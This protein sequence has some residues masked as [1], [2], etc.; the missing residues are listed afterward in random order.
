MT[1]R[2]AATVRRSSGFWERLR[3]QIP[4]G[5]EEVVA[6]TVLRLLLI[7]FIL[8]AGYLLI[9]E[10]KGYVTGLERFQVSPATLTFTATPSWVTP[11]IG[12]QL[13]RLPDLPERFS[14]L[15][16]GL[17]KRVAD[18]YERN[19]WVAEVKLVERHFP[20]RLQVA[21]VLRRPVAAVRYRGAYYL[22]DGEAVRLPLRFGSW[23]QPD[24]QLPIVTGAR[25]QPPRSGAVW[26]DEAVRAG[27]GVAK[28]LQTYGYGCQLGVTAVD[29]GNL[30]GRLRRGDPDIVLHTASRMRI[31]WGRSPLAWQPGGGSQTVTR[32]LLY[33]KR[34]LDDHEIDP[35]RLEYADI[36]FDRLL[37]KP[38]S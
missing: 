27:C 3:A 32:K 21:L 30:G 12:Q 25:T 9:Q 37:V 33:L 15:E 6:Q 5:S 16:P 14:I 35:N 11:E 17:A 7:A 28:L 22:V 38:R 24:F 13:T 20:N 18:A 4:E 10:M 8:V 34:L 36:R 23:P 26:Q 31:L 29:A 1:K 19:A 2:S